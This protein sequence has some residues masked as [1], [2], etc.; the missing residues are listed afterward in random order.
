M[1][2]CVRTFCSAGTKMPR[3]LLQQNMRTTIR[4]WGT[5][6]ISRSRIILGMKMI[7]GMWIFL[8]SRMI[9]GMETMRM[10][11]GMGMMKMMF[12]MK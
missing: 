2:T 12:Q 6:M 5:R 9:W 4:I 8:R 10:I 1:S 7:L 3:H 11:W